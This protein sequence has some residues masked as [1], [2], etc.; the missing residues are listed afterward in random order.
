[1]N[2]P[3]IALTLWTL[4][5]GSASA[6]DAELRV[7]PELGNETTQTVTP[8][9]KKYPFLNAD[10]CHIKLNGADWTQLRT[11]FAATDSNAVRV[12]H[13][14]DSHIQ[15][16]GSTGRTRKR[17]QERYGNAGRG[18]TA[19]MRLA[20]TNGASDYALRSTTD[21]KSAR[22]LKT[23]W[24]VAPGLTGVGVQPATGGR[25]D[26]SVSCGDAFD[27]LRIFTTG[28]DPYV[29]SLQ[30]EVI[31][32]ISGVA[33]G[34]T[35]VL[36]TQAETAV[37]LTLRDGG[38]LAGIELLHGNC[39]VEYSAIGNNGATCSN[40]N[41]LPGFAASTSHLRPDL[42]IISLGT[43]E[44]FGRTSTE[45]MKAQ[46]HTLV[47]SLLEHN[48][49][50]TLLL[51]TPQE[52]YR[53]RY[54]RRGKSKRRTRV[55]AINPNIEQMRSA[56]NAYGAEHNIAV[57]DWYAAAGG[58]GSGAKWLSNHLMNTDRVHLT[59]DGYHLMGDMLADALLNEL[60]RTEE[61]ESD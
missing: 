45:A 58:A 7:N 38:S 29:E 12:L 25:Y 42:I 28:T 10:A 4:A 22:L 37:T 53:R 59:W 24:A 9:R 11:A 6:Q 16:E 46:L 35:E 18:L 1:M 5:C 39:G 36:L 8:E 49:D 60:S 20:G 56:I 51:T 48:P 23:P 54:V 47:C 61:N 30:P 40:Y 26:I 17:L 15:A 55:Y 43:N 52:C 32:G 13:I 50:A 44:A 21:M 33:E 57:F 2:R 19:P 3:A 14:G 27:C 31:A 34:V 41:T